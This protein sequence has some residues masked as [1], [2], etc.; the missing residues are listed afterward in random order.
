MKV[1][2]TSRST[3]GLAAQRKPTLSQTATPPLSF[4]FLKTRIC[5][6]SE[7]GMGLIYSHKSNRPKCIGSHMDMDVWKLTNKVSLLAIR[8]GCKLGRCIH[9]FILINTFCD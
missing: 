6:A 3:E 2:Y 8:Q 5:R 7:L 1:G 4:F 9:K